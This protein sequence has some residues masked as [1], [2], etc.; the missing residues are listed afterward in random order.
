MFVVTL[1]FADKTKAPRLMDGHDAWIRRGFDDA[2]FLL[3]G[4][5]RPNAGGA[6]LAHNC[7]RAEIERRVQ[8]DPFVAEGVVAAEIVEIAPGRADPRLAFLQA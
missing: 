5:I 7:S 4:S 6:I 3:V 1:R 2:V 8:D